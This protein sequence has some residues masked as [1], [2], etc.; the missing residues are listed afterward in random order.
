METLL[1]K[2]L[3]ALRDENYS[4]IDKITKQPQMR[5]ALIRDLQHAMD[6]AHAHQQAKTLYSALQ[7]WMSLP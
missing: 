4:E 2:F 1:Q 6:Q 7:G 3:N 5:A